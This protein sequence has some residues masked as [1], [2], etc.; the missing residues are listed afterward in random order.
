MYLKRNHSKSDSEIRSAVEHIAED[1]SSSIGIT[2]E[3][4]SDKLQFSRTGVSGFIKVNPD[5]VE[6]EIKKSFFIPISE[7]MIEDKVNDYFDKYL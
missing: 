5:S 4:I 6:V 3:W 2:Y 1:L 7:S